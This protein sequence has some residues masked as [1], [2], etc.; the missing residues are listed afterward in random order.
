M[1]TKGEQLNPPGEHIVQANGVDLC[2]G[3]FGDPADPAILLIH[4]AGSSMLSWD[5]ELCEL[6]AAGRRFVIRYDSRDAGRSVTYEPG[7]PR[8]ALPDLVADAVGLLDSFGLASAHIVGMSAGAAIAQLLALDHPDRVAS[9]TLASSTP[10]IPGEEARDLPGVSEELKASFAGEPPQPD[11]ADR[12]A[13]IDY[14]V[15][16]ERPYAARS[17]PFD[18]AA[19]RDLAGRV[20]DRSANIAA[21]LTNPFIVDAGDPWRQ[22][23]GQVAAP[24]LVVHGTEDP[25]F[26]YGHALALAEEIPGA[27]LLALEQTGHEYFPRATWDLVV[28]AILRHTSGGRRRSGT[29]S[30]RG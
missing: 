8:Y 27:D 17:R 4:G 15:E 30:S 26:P 25:L 1:R 28:P 14:L 7:A 20:F 3:T 5:E 13:V 22:R 19:T 29:L 23:L 12:A 18:A 24:T 16:A 6:L 21:S 11:W 10:G 9:L 2:V